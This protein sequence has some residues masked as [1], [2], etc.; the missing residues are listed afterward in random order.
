MKN[1]AQVVQLRCFIVKGFF[2][3]TEGMRLGF[4]GALG[5]PAEDLA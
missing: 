2:S 4:R 3:G 1:Q 5:F